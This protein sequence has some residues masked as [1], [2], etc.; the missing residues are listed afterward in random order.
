MFSTIGMT[1][2]STGQMSCKCS[3]MSSACSWHTPV[4]FLSLQNT[5]IKISLFFGLHAIRSQCIGLLLSF[6]ETQ[7]IL[8]AEIK[9]FRASNLNIT[10][11]KNSGFSI[12]IFEISVY[13]V[14]SS[15]QQRIWYLLKEIPMFL[16][17]FEMYL[18][19]TKLKM[20]G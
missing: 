5:I 2:L 10:N 14:K 7:S 11:M 3:I 12:T 13:W 20:E 6:S 17:L 8:W 9:M 19:S 4:F 15:P 18:V 1:L 16:M